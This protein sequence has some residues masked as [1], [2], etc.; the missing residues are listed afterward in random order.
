LYLRDTSEKMIEDEEVQYDCDGYT[1]DDGLL[2][3]LYKFVK[4]LSESN[5]FSPTELLD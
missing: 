1:F 2:F 5:Q 3:L 4:D